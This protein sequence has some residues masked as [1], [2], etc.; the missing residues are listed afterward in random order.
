LLR[1]SGQLLCQDDFAIV[2]YFACESIVVY[3]A[4]DRA[5]SCNPEIDDLPPLEAYFQTLSRELVVSEQ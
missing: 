5:F 2:A 4:L 1:D 3:L